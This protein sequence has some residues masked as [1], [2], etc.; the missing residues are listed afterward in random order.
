MEV[1]LDG[2]RDWSGVFEVRMF[3]EQR[4]ESMR[5]WHS[6][7][8]KPGHI[9]VVEALIQEYVMPKDPVNGAAWIYNMR[10]PNAKDINVIAVTNIIVRRG[11]VPEQLMLSSLALIY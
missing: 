5:G 10:H 7:E 1:L 3:L 8:I 6:W 9:E 4:T 11:Y 2:Y